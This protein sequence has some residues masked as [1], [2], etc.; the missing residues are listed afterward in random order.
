M[1]SSCCLKNRLDPFCAIRRSTDNYKNVLRNL[2]MGSTHFLHHRRRCHRQESNGVIPNYGVIPKGTKRPFFRFLQLQQRDRTSNTN[3]VQVGRR[4]VVQ[5]GC[6]C[7]HSSISGLDTSSPSPTSSLPACCECPCKLV[8]CARTSIIFDNF[9]SAK[10]SQ[11][12]VS[13]PA[14][15]GGPTGS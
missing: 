10:F 8:Y 9:L 13:K 7:P 1:C 3:V 12:N 2:V 4:I 14:F 15:R 5:H 6:P 11:S